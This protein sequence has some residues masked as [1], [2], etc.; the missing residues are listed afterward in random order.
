MDRVEMLLLVAV[1]SALILGCR[2]EPRVHAHD[3]EEK[4]ADYQPFPARPEEIVGELQEVNMAS[5]NFVVRME[6]G[7]RQTF[8]FNTDTEVSAPGIDL[9]G[10]KLSM[11]FLKGKE[12]AEVSVRWVPEIPDR[13]AT[14]VAV[15]P[16]DTEGR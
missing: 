2:S 9:S 5:S 12:G 8:R 11:G 6:N 16:M 7:L 14:F 13:R 15:L 1:C 3:E 10:P 4:P